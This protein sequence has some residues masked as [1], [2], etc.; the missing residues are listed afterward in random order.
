MTEQLESTPYLTGRLNLPAA[1][2]IGT[3]TTWNVQ[4]GRRLLLAANTPQVTSL[5]LPAGLL[6]SATLDALASGLPANATFSLDVGNDG[7]A[8]WSANAANN[9]TTASSNLAA[10][11][12][13]WWANHGAPTTGALDVPVK[14]TLSQPGQVL[15]SNLQVTTAGSKQRSVRLNTGTYST[16]N[17][18]FTVGGSGTGPLSVALD[19][20]AN[21]SLDWTWSQ[22]TT[23]PINLTTGNLAAAINAYLSGKSGEVDVPLRFF[24][25]PDAAVTLVDV[26]AVAAPVLDL[27]ATGLHLNSAAS[28]DVAAGPRE[29]DIVPLAVTLNNPSG[30]PSGPVTAAFFATAPGWGDWYVGSAFLANIPA[31]GSAAVGVSW[32]TLGFSGSVPVKAIINPYGRTGETSFANNTANLTV[33]VTPKDPPPVAAFVADKTS[34]T[35]P[36][37][38]KFSDKSSGPI[39][40]WLWNFGDGKSST[41]QNPTY[42]YPYAGKYTVKLTVS[43]PGGANTGTRTNYITVSGTPPPKPVAAFSADKTQGKAP[44]TVKFTDTT[45]NPVT[46]WAWNFGDGQSSTLQHPSHTY[47][48][49]GSYTVTLTATGPGGS[50]SEIKA[51]YIT[52][53]QEPIDP[54]A[55][56]KKHFLPSVRR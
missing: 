5:R 43:G 41:A 23:R 22:N 31:G 3:S 29:G 39:T 9:S 18:Q 42:T 28:A 24:V 26:S 49:P 54:G 11:F 25:A 55:L 19:V 45:Q 47:T 53:T 20:G 36:L 21:G 6:S 8:E 27:T 32:N 46:A 2:A 50:D 4:Y 30:K 40:S 13:A 10:A 51:G 44:L 35:S 15:L 34:G 16:V 7:S 37:T 38:V 48:G 1:I 14:V 33:A 52:V 12:N 17:L 56:G